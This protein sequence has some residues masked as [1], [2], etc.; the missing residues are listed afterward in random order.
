MKPEPEKLIPLHGGYRRLKSF[1]VAQLAYDVTVRSFGRC[2]EKP[3]NAAV[4]YILGSPPTI[5][6]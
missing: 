6:I 2:V 5:A 3:S 4:G 1:Q